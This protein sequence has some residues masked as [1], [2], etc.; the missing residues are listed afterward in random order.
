MLCFSAVNRRGLILPVTLLFLLLLGLLASVICASFLSE[1]KL[2]DNLLASEQ[3]ELVFSSAAEHLR[4][5]FLSAQIRD[6]SAWLRPGK[7]GPYAVKGG[8]EGTLGSYSIRLRRTKGGPAWQDFW[9]G[10]KWRPQESPALSPPREIFLALKKEAGGKREEKDL[11]SLAFLLSDACDENHAL[12]E[13][14]GTYGAEAVNFSEIMS[15]DGSE[16]RFCYRADAVYRERSVASLPYFYGNRKYDEREPL[17]L[18]Q[19]ETRELFDPGTARR[20]ETEECFRGNGRVALKLSA[21]PPRPDDGAALLRGWQ[22]KKGRLYPADDLWKNA[23]AAFFG[24]AVP[25]ITPRA[26]KR[27]A[28]SDGGFVYFADDPALWTSVTNGAFRFVQLRGWVHSETLY[29][30]RPNLPLWLGISGLQKE[31]YYEVFLQ[32]ANFP[33]P[34]KDKTYA[35]KRNTRIA[36]P[37]GKGKKLVEARD[38]TFPYD[39]GKPL[40]SDSKGELELTVES[41]GD[42]APNLRLRLNS[43]YFRRP[44]VV[45]I[46]NESEEPLLLSNWSLSVQT[47]GDPVT[48]GVLPGHAA[49]RGGERFYLTD[50]PEIF[51]AESGREILRWENGRQRGEVAALPEADWGL[52]YRISEVRET[53]QGAQYHSLVKCES[54]FWRKDELLGEIVEIVRGRESADSLSPRGLRFPVEGGNGSRTLV[55]SNLRLERYAGLREGD[56]L[57]I[58]GLPRHL[59]YAALTLKNEYAQVAARTRGVMCPEDLPAGASLARVSGQWRPCAAPFKAFEKA[60]TRK[61]FDVPLKGLSQ[62]LEFLAGQP[63]D[64]LPLEEAVLSSSAL[65]FETAEL[66]ARE[67]AYEGEWKLAGGRLGKSS[68]GLAFEGPAFS[69]GFWRGQ[70]VRFL[71]GRMKG[72]VFAVTG[73]LHNTVLPLSRSLKGRELAPSPGD[74]ASLGPGYREIFYVSDKSGQSGVWTFSNMWERAG[75]ALY[76]KGLSDAVVSG[77]F[78][79]ENHNAGIAP[80]LFD[81][82]QGRWEDFPPFRYHKNDA[83]FLTLIQDRFVSPRGLLKIRLRSL[84]LNDP[85]GS[86]TAWFQGLAVVPPLRK[87]SAAAGAPEDPPPSGWAIPLTVPWRGFSSLEGGAEERLK[88]REKSEPTEAEYLLEVTLSKSAGGKTRQALRK[89]RRYL[90]RIGP[91]SLKNGRRPLL[92][93][94]L[95]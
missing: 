25:D 1:K 92:F 34:T 54:A 94:P 41:P 75:G 55:F 57:R 85:L 44:D 28:A 11:R 49:L 74:L 9:D 2:S 91:P 19:P 63:E 17:G 43:L 21:E 13:N 29:A 58:L 81:F 3:E 45:A 10:E 26:V 53:R 60:R 72:E 5:L 59:E 37:A 7:A 86:G 84:D 52:D 35:L 79:E 50:Q 64:P 80:A 87:N 38:Y 46:R 62:V 18:D 78:L 14:A 16:L 6:P 82:E 93:R 56:T 76:L 47:G 48:V 32:D 89:L 73:S 33:V 67:A 8:D 23:S 36:L 31:K 68:R 12:Q 70:K 39:E 24:L 22:K 15:D 88:I 90:V 83:A 27:I 61:F 71:S 20:I 40:K 42:A 4:S 30:E 69:P 51:C 95:P 77:E 66:P 65:T